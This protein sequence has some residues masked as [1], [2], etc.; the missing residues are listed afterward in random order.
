MELPFKEDKS[1]DNVFIRKFDSSTPSEEF[2]W[3]IDP[4][5]RLIE[6]ISDTDWMLQLEDE[7]P[8]K[9][10]GEIRIPAHVYHRLIKGEGDLT[11]KL[12]KII[13]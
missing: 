7:L 6:A 5:D 3:H 10:M 2:M 11:I 8:K 12:T 9:I 13:E 1:S 4:E